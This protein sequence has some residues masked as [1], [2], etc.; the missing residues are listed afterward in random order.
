MGADRVWLLWNLQAG[1]IVAGHLLA[2]LVAH[3]VA[4]RLY[5]TAAGAARSQGPL[6]LLMVGYTVL[7]LWLL[8][9]PTA[10]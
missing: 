7:G 3:V 8:A 6:A 5:G 1:V 2:I 9:A 10:G 4:F